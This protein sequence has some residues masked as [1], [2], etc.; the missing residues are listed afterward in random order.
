MAN[1]DL[2]LA[3]DPSFPKNELEFHRRFSNERACREYL[4]NI[5][6]P[7][8]FVCP[9]CGSKKAYRVEHRDL[10]VCSACKYQCSLRSGTVF[11]NSGK[12]L[13]LWFLA[14]FHVSNSK[15]GISAL[16]LQRRLGIGSYRTA[17]LWLHKIRECL[18][19]TEPLQGV[20]EID[21]KFLGARAGGMSSKKPGKRSI[22]RS[23][24]RKAI[25]AAAIED[26]GVGAGRL[27]LRL[28]P[29]DRSWSLIPFVKETVKAGSTLKADRWNA[30]TPLHADDYVLDAL[31]A[32]TPAKISEHLPNV[33]RAFGLLEHWMLGTFHGSYSPKHLQAY[34]DEFSFRYNV[35][36]G[37]RIFQ[38]MAVR[39]VSRKT[40][41]FADLVA[42][43]DGTPKHDSWW[44]G[45]RLELASLREATAG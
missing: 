19:T 20:V 35:P 2:Q 38:K 13:T 27:R 43:V 36:V 4:V 22:G 29:D 7:N 17:W 8:G 33:H 42:N 15:R 25:I 9:K 1:L 11:E 5:R 41:R 34:L 18:R 32:N 39:L 21:E 3:S 37:P 40:R 30:Y 28:V 10:W 44:K 31:L 23:S 16:E 26:R 14:M 12:P 6:W 24:E 45:L